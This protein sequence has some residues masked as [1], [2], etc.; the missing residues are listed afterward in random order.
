MSGPFVGLLFVEGFEYHVLKGM[1]RL[2]RRDR[3][4]LWV[5]IFDE[6]YG[7]VSKFLQEYHYEQI[8]VFEGDNYIFRPKQ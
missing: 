7:E 2:L 4:L 1:G 6:H 8:E 3:P 5:E